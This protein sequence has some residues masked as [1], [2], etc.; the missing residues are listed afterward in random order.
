MQDGGPLCAI[1]CG[2]IFCREPWGK[3]KRWPDPWNR[4]TCAF[5]GTREEKTPVFRSQLACQYM[6]EQLRNHV[7]W[8]GRLERCLL[9]RFT[10][11]RSIEQLSVRGDQPN[12]LRYRCTRGQRLASM[13]A[14]RIPARCAHQEPPR[15]SWFGC[16]V[17]K[18]SSGCHFFKF[19][20]E[21]S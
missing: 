5:E 11:S 21:Q 13:V 6:S 7:I 2:V 9:V 19:S 8:W 3:G 17:A 15:D 4:T 18:A 10:K 1:G 20:V 14:R 16:C 12:P